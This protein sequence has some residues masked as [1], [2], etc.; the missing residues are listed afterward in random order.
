MLAILVISSWIEIISVSDK[1]LFNKN[2][3]I[4]DKYK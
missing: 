3:D 2:I 1:R 4:S